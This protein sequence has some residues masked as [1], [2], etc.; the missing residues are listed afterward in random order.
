MLNKPV[1][2]VPPRLIPLSPTHDVKRLVSR[3]WTLLGRICQTEKYKQRPI[4]PQDITITQ[5]PDR[6]AQLG[7]RH[8]RDLI[9]HETRCDAQTINLI[10]LAQNA[11]QRRLGLIR[12]KRADCNGPRMPKTIVL[13]NHNG[14]R[15]FRHSH[16]R[17]QRS[18]FRPASF[19]KQIGNR[20]DETLVVPAAALAATAADWRCAS[21][22]NPAARTSATQI[23]IIAQPQGALPFTMGADFV[24]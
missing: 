1:G 3:R 21:C 10:R 4:Q 6:H 8:G 5:T 23:W 12:R 13:D 14:A 11:E 20:V 18:K 16:C 15:F 2:L 7:F 22:R 19:L 17:P 24:A 9:H